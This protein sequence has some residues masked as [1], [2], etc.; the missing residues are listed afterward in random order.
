MEFLIFKKYTDKESAEALTNPLQA[1]GIAFQITRDIE[2]LD[3]LYGTNPTTEFYY[4]KIKSED[5]PKA[6]ALLLDLGNTDLNTVDKTHYLFEFTDEELFDLLSKPDEWNALDYQLAKKILRERGREVNDEIIESLKKQRI[7]ELA[8]PDESNR[9]W[10]FIGYLAILFG[11]L[12]AIIVGWHLFTYK[13]TLPDGQRV[14]EYSEKDRRH[15]KRIFYLGM[16]VFYISIII[17][18][19]TLDW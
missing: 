13:K 18:L 5:F 8:K 12:F 4:V 11:G 3:V 9:V 14:Y 2:N 17:R 7:V 1:H 15:G 10:I 19:A 6:N 16:I